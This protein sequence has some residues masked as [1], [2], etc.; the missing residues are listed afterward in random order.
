M[1]SSNSTVYEDAYSLLYT[2]PMVSVSQP[3]TLRKLANNPPP[4]IQV[5]QFPPEPV[6]SQDYETTDRNEIDLRLHLAKLQSAEVKN[7]VD[8]LFEG[9]RKT[10]IY[11][12]P[13]SHGPGSQYLSIQ[14]FLPP[15]LSRVPL[16]YGKGRGKDDRW[17]NDGWK[18]END[19]KKEDDWKKEGDWK[20]D[21]WT[22]DKQRNH[23][24]SHELQR[25]LEFQ[26]S[27]ERNQRSH[28]LQGSHELQR[29]PQNDSSA[30]QRKSVYLGNRLATTAQILGFLPEETEVNED[31]VPSG[32]WTNPL[33]QAA[34]AR[35]RNREPYVKRS[36]GCVFAFL[37]F[38]MLRS[39]MNLVRPRS[40][41]MWWTIE[42]AI[43]CAIVLVFGLSVHL[44]MTACDECEDLP[45]SNAQRKLIGLKPIDVVDE[46]TAL[47]MAQRRYGDVGFER[48]MYK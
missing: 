15:S 20:N 28:E 47:E 16:R 48:P 3:T 23:D 39:A 19:W 38:Q 9:A 33:M 35:Q 8:L 30:L 10:P 17:K 12:K 29:N 1:D 7:E 4:N 13:P 34:L 36:V 21:G 32:S 45:L 37:V 26:R 24:R 41:T 46:A 43:T 40:S 5:R 14:L 31:E 44:A 18:N 2:K 22:N 6:A 27:H 42:T 25:S 11:Y